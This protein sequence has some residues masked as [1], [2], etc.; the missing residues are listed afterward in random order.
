MRRAPSEEV[1]SEQEILAGFS[2][3]FFLL[4]SP[5][6]PED[7]IWT[8]PAI[9]CVLLPCLFRVPRRLRRR[10]R[11]GGFYATLNSDFGSVIRRCANRPETWINKKIIRSFE[12]MHEAGHA[13]S[14]EIWQNTKLVGGLYGLA[15]GGLFAGESMF[16][17]TPSASQIALLHLVCHMKTYRLPLLDNQ[18]ATPHLMRFGALKLPHK[19]F[20]LLSYYA[21]HLNVRFSSQPFEADSAAALQRISQMS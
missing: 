16:S 8:R 21:Q 9:R 1:I 15:I 13:H 11:C 10:I 3:G 6:D 18:Y 20:M 17:E 4:D 5:K 14:I 2:H 19:E 7:V 12:R